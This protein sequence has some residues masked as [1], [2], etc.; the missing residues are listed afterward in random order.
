MGDARLII[1]PG[2]VGQ[3]RD[4]DPRAAYAILDAEAMTWEHRRIGYLV[5]ETQSR[6]RPHGLPYKLVARLQFGW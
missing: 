6:M 5:E 1:N 3:P 4:S 2:S